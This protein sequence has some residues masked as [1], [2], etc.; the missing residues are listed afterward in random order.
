MPPKQLI[1]F[2]YSISENEIFVKKIIFLPKELVFGI[3]Y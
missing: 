1:N 2:E 3:K